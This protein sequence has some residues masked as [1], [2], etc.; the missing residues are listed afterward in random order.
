ML[1]DYGTDDNMGGADASEFSNLIKDEDI[2]LEERAKNPMFAAP[3]LQEGLPPVTCNYGKADYWD[4]RYMKSKEIFEWYHEYPELKDIITMY[5]ARDGKVCM[6]GC[7]NSR[8]SEDM[9]Y[10]E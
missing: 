8:L 1:E 4:E 2:D 9:Y 5:C 6:L 3:H 7:G 10:G